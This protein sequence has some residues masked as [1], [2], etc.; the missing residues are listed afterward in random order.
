MLW[1]VDLGA[2]EDVRIEELWMKRMG[3]YEACVQSSIDMGKCE[4]WNE[5]NCNNSTSEYAFL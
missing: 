3:N 2:M 5:E 1:I 4:A